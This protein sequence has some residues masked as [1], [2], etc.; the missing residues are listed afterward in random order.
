MLTLKKNLFFKKY[1]PY[2]S[3]KFVNDEL[4]DYLIRTMDT[5]FFED[6]YKKCV[7]KLNTFCVGKGRLAVA[8]YLKNTQQPTSID[9]EI[10]VNNETNTDDVLT[11][12]IVK[13]HFNVDEL[14]E[15]LKKVCEV[16]K[17]KFI[18][19]LKSTNFSSV[20]GQDVMYKD[21][22]IIFKSYVD[23]AVECVPRYCVFRLNESNMLKCTMSTVNNDY[24]LLRFSYN[25]HM[26]SVGKPILWYKDD[27]VI[28]QQEYFPLD[29]YFCNIM[30]K[31]NKGVVKHYK[32]VKMLNNIL[33]VDNLNDVIA[34]QIECLLFNI[35]YKNEK[36]I[37]QRTMIINNLLKKLYKDT[38]ACHVNY[39][40]V[41]NFLKQH[42]KIYNIC[43]VKNI[44]F[45]CGVK[46]GMFIVINLYFKKRFTYCIDD[47]T[48]QINFP[49][50]IWN[51][52]HLSVC[53]KR[54]IKLTN[55]MLDL[56]VL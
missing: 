53:W 8:A 4:N 7:T 45:E 10:Y 19:I 14:Q 9:L 43:D 25:I 28:Q 52:N 37:N 50:H 29:F 15:D 42:D 22:F 12:D 51:Y 36:K 31:Y 33:I 40:L 1:I 44:M 34:E 6:I 32:V 11:P 27:Y 48:C 17:Q 30:I 3:K 47:I 23:E 49:Y 56:R 2:N 13:Q 46:T 18:N 26:K 21:S 54:F 16:H 5:N 38:N 24:C 20:F 35:F 55:D 39:A 41:D